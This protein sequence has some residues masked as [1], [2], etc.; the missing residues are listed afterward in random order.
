MMNGAFIADE[1]KVT[2]EDKASLRFGSTTSGCCQAEIENR[3]AGG[4]G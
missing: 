3:D 4:C 2:D 1:G